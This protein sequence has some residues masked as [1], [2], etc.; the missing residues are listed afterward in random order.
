MLGHFIDALNIPAAEARGQRELNNS[1]KLP[2]RLGGHGAN[3]S[4]ISEYEKLGIK[5]LGL[6]KGDELFCECVL[7]DGWEKKSTSH[8]M[9]N[10]LLDDK[11]RVRAT[12]FYKGVFYDRDAF[13]HLEKRFSVHVI[14]YLPSDQKGK[15]KEIIVK[16]LHE[17]WEE[18]AREFLKE[19]GQIYFVTEENWGIVRYQPKFVKTKEKVWVPRFKSS[20]S[21]R[22]N[23]P[24]YFEIRDGKEIIFSTKDNPKFFKRKYR[25]ARHSGWWKAYEKFQESVRKEANAWLNA[26]YPN[27][28]NFYTYWD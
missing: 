26:R 6:V 5:V 19:D 21:E 10:E 2:S 12:Y 16:G 1:C 9:W 7:P 4:A 18:G 17:D 11:G 14:D 22:N 13:I 15:E 3:G 28:D 8:S 23:T 20:Y 25:K 27:W 24:Y